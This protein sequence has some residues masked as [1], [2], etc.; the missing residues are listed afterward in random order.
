MNREALSE[1]SRGRVAPPPHVHKQQRRRDRVGVGS[2]HNWENSRICKR[3][4]VLYYSRST[5]GQI[6]WSEAPV[7]Q[8]VIRKDSRLLLVILRDS[9]EGGQNRGCYARSNLAI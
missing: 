5:E 6:V 7:L 2:S 8:I 9:S 4:S 3:V 1:H